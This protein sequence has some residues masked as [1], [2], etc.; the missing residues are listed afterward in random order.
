MFSSWK[1]L[2]S[3]C[4]LFFYFIFCFF[5]FFFS[6]R[7]RHT[8]SKRDW[9]SDVCSSDLYTD[10]Y[11]RSMEQL[12]VRRVDAYPSVT[13]SMAQIIAYVEGLIERGYAYQVDGDVY[14]EVGR[15]PRYGQLSGR[16]EETGLEEAR[17]ENEPGKR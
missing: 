3:V 12:N 9:S 7:R 14:F 5:F 10:S 11:F 16:V 1:F 15:F 4:L 2:Y 6:S 13:G 17:V 8:R